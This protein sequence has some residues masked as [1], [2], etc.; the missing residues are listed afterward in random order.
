MTPEEAKT[1]AERAK[2]LLGDE[3]LRGSLAALTEAAIAGCAQAKDEK[4]SWR[5]CAT[6]KA[7]MDIARGLA[8]H[9]ETAKV[10][11]FNQKLTLRERLGI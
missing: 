9:L 10:V 7:C 2:Q 3:L 11:E 1:R 6:L 5:A 4:E 8:S